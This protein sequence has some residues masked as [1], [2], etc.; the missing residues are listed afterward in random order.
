LNA[1]VFP[2]FVLQKTSPE[3]SNAEPLTTPLPMSVIPGVNGFGFGAEKEIVGI[4][5]VT[6][7]SA[8][9]STRSISSESFQEFA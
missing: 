1:I 5:R 7:M 9:T 6:A 3:L 8:T 4:A 2:I